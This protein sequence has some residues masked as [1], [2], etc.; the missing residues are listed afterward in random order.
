[1]VIQD[2]E[3]YERAFQEMYRLLMNGG[4]FIFSILHSCFVT[5]GSGWEK[6]N[7]GEKIHWK[8]NNYFY[9]GAYEQRLGDKERMILFH[10]TLTSYMNTLIKTGFILEGLVEPKPSK[11][12][13]SKYP[14]FEEDLR[15]ADFIVFK[16]RK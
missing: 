2:L 4:C 6:N 15:C 1:M 13:L 8:V 11:E 9:E 3:D 5:P 12:M 10:R 7:N 14:S 16:L